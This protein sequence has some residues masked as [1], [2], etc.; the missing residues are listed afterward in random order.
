MIKKHVV[1]IGLVVAML[2]GSA[3]GFV[4]CGEVEPEPHTHS[5]ALVSKKEATCTEA[6][7]EAYYKC[8][9]CD[10]LFS[11]KEGKNEISAPEAIAAAHKIEAVAKQDATCTVEGYEAYYK[12]SVCN[13]LFSD[14][15]GKHT[16]TAAISIPVTAHT[17]VE[18]PKKRP[19]CTE[20]GYEEH[21]KCSVCNTLFSDEEG[22][23]ALAAPVAIPAAHRIVAVPKKDA[24]CSAAGYEAHYKCSICDKLFSDEAGKTEITSATVIPASGK[25]DFGFHYT[26]ETLPA[27]VAE[28]G[29][30]VSK[31]AHCDETQNIPY[32]RGYNPFTESQAV[33]DKLEIAGKHYGLYNSLGVCIAVRVNKP[34]TYTISAQNVLN[35]SEEPFR[36]MKL[37]ISAHQ[38]VN[39][40]RLVILGGT[41][42]TLPPAASI[43]NK[44]KPKIA[45]DFNEPEFSTIS[46]KLEEGD[47][48]FAAAAGI[49]INMQFF[50]KNMEN[51]HINGVLF[52]VE[53][54]A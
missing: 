30:I 2:L 42:N 18:V 40:M 33:Y 29:T 12:C 50:V 28:G 17:I 7:Y 45:I 22:K 34:G 49:W 19:T 54:P 47:V 37:S 36:L 11:D 53:T 4:G 27:P 9:G 32:D 20:A 38:D 43:V 24:T 5:L 13:T 3:F 51:S 8:S 16:I 15:E 26:S 52:T 21:Y 31:C 23:T 25:H 10:K 48:D 35:L 6:G 39:P 46:I 14:A 44:F 1:S 41:W